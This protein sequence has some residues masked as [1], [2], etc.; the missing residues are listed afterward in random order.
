MKKILLLIPCLFVINVMSAQGI[1]QYGKIVTN[2][3]LNSLKVGSVTYPN[4]AGENGQVLTTNGIGTASWV[5]SIISAPIDVNANNKTL[6]DSDSGKIIYLSPYPNN[7]NDPTTDN[8]SLFLNTNLPDG[9]TASIINTGP[10]NTVSLQADVNM[11]YSA[12]IGG[13][14]NY[15]NIRS[16]GV[17]KLYVITVIVDSVVTKRYYLSGDFIVNRA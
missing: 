2:A 8:T 4:S 13:V 17:V 7:F 10:D 12:E 14:G 1:D 3:T 11:F 15:F 6:S 9:F 5:G 16:G